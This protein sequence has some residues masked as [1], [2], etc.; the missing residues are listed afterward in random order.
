METCASDR[1]HPIVTEV[2]EKMPLESDE[3]KLHL[4]KHICAP[5]KCCSPSIH[6]M[7]LDFHISSKLLVS[8]LQTHA[9]FNVA[10]QFH[11]YLLE[12]I[13]AQ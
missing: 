13:S 8:M 11:C 4:E 5:L 9:C 2:D 1:P 6:H 3:V 12:L 10:G 7:A